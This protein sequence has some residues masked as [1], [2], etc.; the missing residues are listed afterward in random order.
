MPNKDIDHPVH[1]SAGHS[2][3]SQ[4]LMASSGGQQR[5][6]DVCGCTH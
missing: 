2:M 6:I 3:G 4:E 1:T 5:L